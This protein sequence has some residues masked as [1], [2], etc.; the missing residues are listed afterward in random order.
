LVCVV[1][2]KWF[3]MVLV[4]VALTPVTYMVVSALQRAAGEDYYDRDTNFT[5]F[6]LKV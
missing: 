5:P 3:F 4:E 2:F 6:S 1:L